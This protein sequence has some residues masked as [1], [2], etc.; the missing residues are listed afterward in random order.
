MEQSDL[1]LVRARRAE[2]AQQR[3]AL[4][5]EDADLAVT[6]RTLEKLKARKEAAKRP[7]APLVK[8]SSG[9]ERLSIKEK[10]IAV[11]RDAPTVWAPDTSV[12]WNDIQD[13]FGVA[14]NKNSFHPLMHSLV[15]DGIVVREGKQIALAERL[16]TTKEAAE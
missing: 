7:E 9:P 4:D 6:E 2:I 16:Q 5:N 14:V 8:S 15:S 13:R 3:L 10:I 1:D 12:V 11:L